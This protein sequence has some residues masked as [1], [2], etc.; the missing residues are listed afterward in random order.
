[1]KNDSSRQKKIQFELWCVNKFWFLRNILAT[2][3]CTKLS[4][5]M[6]GKIV[7]K[8]EIFQSLFYSIAWEIN[9]FYQPKLKLSLFRLLLKSFIIKEISFFNKM[10]HIFEIRCHILRKIKKNYKEWASFVDARS[11]LS[12]STVIIRSPHM[13]HLSLLHGLPTNCASKLIPSDVYSM[14]K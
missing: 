2:K 11:R 1:M 10:K 9:I 3:D 14:T 8:K 13:R 12:K 5:D 6:S 4:K 7:E